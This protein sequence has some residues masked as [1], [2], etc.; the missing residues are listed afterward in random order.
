[1]VYSLVVPPA[2]SHVGILRD[3]EMLHGG[4]KQAVHCTIS[5]G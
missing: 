2:T 4:I 5:I 1:M 3:V